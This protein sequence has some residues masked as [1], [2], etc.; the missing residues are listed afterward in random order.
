[1]PEKLLNARVT[2]WRNLMEWDDLF[3]KIAAL[4]AVK[5]KD[6]STKVGCVIVDNKNRIVSVGFNGSP[7]G[8]CDA[9]DRDKKL[10]RTVHAEAN[11]LHFALR[12]VT[13]C[14]IYI[15]HPPCAHCAGHLIQ[16]GIAEIIFPEPSADFMSRWSANYC[17]AVEMFLEA[18]VSVREF[19]SSTDDTQ[20]YGDK[21]ES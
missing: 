6:K 17:E 8:V 10:M 9:D 5:S 4:V 3:I 1:M 21:H 19:N 7:R 16:R 18:G 20:S 14:R 15:T 13:G 2:V 11:A 12:D